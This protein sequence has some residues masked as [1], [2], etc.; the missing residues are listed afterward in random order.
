[1]FV[2]I[3][4][5]GRLTRFL[6]LNNTWNCNL[7][8]IKWCLSIVYL[9]YARLWLFLTLFF[10]LWSMFSMVHTISP[11]STVTTHHLLNRCFKV[12]KFLELTLVSHSEL[13]H[14][15]LGS[16]FLYI[17]LIKNIDIKIINKK[18]LNFTVWCSVCEHCVLSFLLG[19]KFQ[20]VMCPCPD[21]NRRQQSSFLI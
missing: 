14:V 21:L 17:I 7:R 8:N 4:R 15:F 10:F 9:R 19:E 18:C 6:F 11:K 2:S 20:P 13:S 3:R 1:M 12:W 5:P 16:V